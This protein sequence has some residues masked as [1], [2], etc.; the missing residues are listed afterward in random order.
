M[1]SLHPGLCGSPEPRGGG[2]LVPT[3]RRS[4]RTP[5]ARGPRHQ[6]LARDV[7]RA[8]QFGGLPLPPSALLA[9][10]PGCCHSLPLSLM[11]PSLSALAQPIHQFSPSVK[12][13]P[14][15]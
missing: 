12:N 7:P 5:G 4:Q 15:G 2:G 10:P 3:P 14:L 8:E 9:L 13:P 6:E 11:D 1:S